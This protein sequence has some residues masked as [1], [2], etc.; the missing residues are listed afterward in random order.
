M[1]RWAVTRRWTVGVVNNG[2]ADAM[3]AGGGFNPSQ[4]TG[5]GT[6]ATGVSAGSG[7][8]LLYGYFPTQF[9]AA[10]DTTGLAF[11]RD[12]G[13]TD[14]VIVT[15][16]GFGSDLVLADSFES[17]TAGQVRVWSERDPFLI[18]TGATNAVDEDLG[19]AG[20]FG[21]NTV[22]RGRITFNRFAPAGLFISDWSTAI[23][24]NGAASTL[25]PRPQRHREF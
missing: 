2:P 11:T 17:L 12:D 21:S 24:D 5:Q 9:G 13:V 10:A 22:T 8:S 20:N 4:F 15:V 1:S 23:P 18:A 7:C 6:C 14:D 25:G 19:P 16:S 3:V